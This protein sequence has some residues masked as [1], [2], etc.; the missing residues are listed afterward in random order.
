MAGGKRLSQLPEATDIQQDDL[1]YIV[2]AGFGKKCTV[3][4]LKNNI[5]GTQNPTIRYSKQGILESSI[6]TYKKYIPYNTF[7][8]SKIIFS[9]NVTGSS[10]ISIKK[11]GIEIKNTTLTDYITEVTDTT[12]FVKGDYITVDIQNSTLAEDLVIEFIGTKG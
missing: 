12:S 6:G 10:Q 7:I 3:S 4:S 2:Q 1:L 8:L 5:T 11:N 9:V